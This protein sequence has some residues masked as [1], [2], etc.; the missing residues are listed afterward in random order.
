[1][2]VLTSFAKKKEGKHVMTIE[3]TNNRLIMVKS[4]LPTSIFDNTHSNMENNQKHSDEDSYA[5]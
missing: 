3:S 2:K 4:V 1:M 5:P